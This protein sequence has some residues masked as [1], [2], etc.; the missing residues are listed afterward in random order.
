MFVFLVL[1]AL[2]QL[3]SGSVV[4]RHVKFW[5]Y[6]AQTILCGA[7][8]LWFRHC[9]ESHRLKNVIFTLLIALTVFAIWIAPQQFLNFAP[10][11]VG[12]DPSVLVSN[13]ATYWSTIL[14]RFL[15][16]VIVVPVME[17]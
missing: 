16:L 14:F 17:E 1:L 8:L 2:S 13:A 7:L 3:L 4:L 5:I 10:R 15:R 11:T 12:F 9:Y 6:P